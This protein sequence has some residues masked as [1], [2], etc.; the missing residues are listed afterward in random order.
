MTTTPNFNDITDQVSEAFVKGQ[1]FVT[2]TVEAWAGYALEAMKVP[3][4]DEI[5]SA[6]ELVEQAF[7]QAQK[8]L[9]LQRSTL[10]N[11]AEAWAA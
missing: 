5:P 11:L 8:L 2:E 4:F 9:D 3:S 1:Q 10:K 7:D 6:T